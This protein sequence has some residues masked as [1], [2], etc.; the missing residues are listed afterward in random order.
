M[1][2]ILL[3][4]DSFCDKEVSA[5]CFTVIPGIVVGLSVGLDTEGY[6]SQQRC[7]SCRFLFIVAH[8]CVKLPIITGHCKHMSVIVTSK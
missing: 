4:G 2:V 8:Y 1:N 6:G 3:S 5:G 7:V